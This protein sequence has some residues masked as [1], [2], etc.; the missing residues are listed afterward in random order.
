LTRQY[1]II[2][3]G[4]LKVRRKIMSKW[5]TK[6][7]PTKNGRYLVTLKTSFGNQ[8]RQADRVEYPKGNWY[9][10]ILPSCSSASNK[11]VI[12]WQKCPEPYN[13]N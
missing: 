13:E 6:N 9:W 1:L 7:P 11:E 12:A 4:I 8:V 2:F 3:V 10:S 5:A